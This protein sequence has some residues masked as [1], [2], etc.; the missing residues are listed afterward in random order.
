M[1]E[2]TSM[3]NNLK[4][5]VKEATNYIIIH[6]ISIFVQRKSIIFLLLKFLNGS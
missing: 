6:I 5:Y 4:I 2:Q 1:V 3:N